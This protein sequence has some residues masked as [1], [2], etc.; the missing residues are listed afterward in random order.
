MH[1]VRLLRQLNSAQYL[2]PE[3]SHSHK[4]AKCKWLNRGSH[5]STTPASGQGNHFLREI[6]SND[7]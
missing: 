6:V 1:R 3:P 4:C 7:W 2:D 5:D